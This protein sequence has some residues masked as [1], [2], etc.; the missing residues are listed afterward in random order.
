LLQISLLVGAIDPGGFNAKTKLGAGRHN[1]AGITGIGARLTHVLIQ[2]VL[3]FD[4]FALKAGRRHIR[5]VIGDDFNIGL[6]GLHA[7]GG[8]IECEHGLVKSLF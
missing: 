7:G 6:L 8:D 4:A 3:K 2:Q 1:G 5:D